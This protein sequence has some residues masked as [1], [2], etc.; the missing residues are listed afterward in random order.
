MAFTAPTMDDLVVRVGN[1]DEDK[2][3]ANTWASQ[4][5]LEEV[6]KFRMDSDLYS[7]ADEATQVKAI[8]AAYKDIDKLSW[9]SYGQ[10]QNREHFEFDIGRNDAPVSDTDFQRVIIQAQANQVMYILAGTQ[11]RDMAAQGISITRALQG[12]ETEIMGYRGP[13]CTEALEM[14]SGFIE[15]NPRVKRMG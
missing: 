9:T 15:M 12:A 4:D 2:L 7:E 1:G 6:I 11:V 8:V 14:L 10:A 3:T 13:V 5:D